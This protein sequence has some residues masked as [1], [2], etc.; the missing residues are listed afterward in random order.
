MEL[1]FISIAQ[2]STSTST[3]MY[4]FVGWNELS[5]GKLWELIPD[6]YISATGWDWN[7][8]NINFMIQYWYKQYQSNI[9]D[10]NS[11]TIRVTLTST[12]FSKSTVRYRYHTVHYL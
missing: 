3:E 7:L 4:H 2:Y 6:M 8:K 5:R 9:F 10:L 1:H 12:F 11:S